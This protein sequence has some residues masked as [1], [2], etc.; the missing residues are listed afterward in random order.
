MAL[1]VKNQ[2]V[3]DKYYN[4]LITTADYIKCT[5]AYKYVKRFKVF[6]R[7]YVHWRAVEYKVYECEKRIYSHSE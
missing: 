6:G 7:A 4:N 3:F 1:S 5:D 2:E